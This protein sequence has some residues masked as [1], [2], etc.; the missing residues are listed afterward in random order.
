MVAKTGNI[1]FHQELIPIEDIEYLEEIKLEDEEA[2]LDERSSIL[3]HFNRLEVDGRTLYLTG[4]LGLIA[5][6]NDFGKTWERFDEVYQ[7]SFFDIAR[8]QR[9]N[10][11]VVGLRGN[12]FRSLKN[13]T[14]WQPSD[15]GTTA[16]LNS[17]VLANDE[18][19]YLVGNNGVVLESVDDGQT[20][21]QH[22]QADGKSI[23]DAVWFKDKLIAATE[24]GIKEIQLI[25]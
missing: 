12:V 22:I 21:R 3:P 20:F 15:S 14:P 8:T 18:T 23:I 4:E 11:L 5:K 24:V 17:I 9:G 2:Y 10:L 25:K 7:G 16:L 19:F 6:S 1:E 13:G